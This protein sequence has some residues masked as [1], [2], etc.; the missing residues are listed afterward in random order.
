MPLNK[1]K[2]KMFKSVGWTF[3]P[4]AGCTHGCKYC[5]AR[6]LTERWGRSFKPQL[7]EHF[8]KDKMPGDGSWI[9][10]GSMGDV[11]C[12]G[13]PDEWILRLL[14]FIKECEADNK[15]LL[16]TKNPRRLK[17]F[18]NMLIPIRGKVVVGTTIETNR[19]T[20]WT[21]APTTFARALNIAYLKQY[22]GFKT[23]ISL[24][25]LSDFDLEPLMVMV[26]EIKPEA[27]EVGL[28]NYTS[29]TVKPPDWKIVA[30]IHWLREMNIPYVLKDNLK[31]L[32]AE[33]EK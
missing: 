13:V 28:E 2:G 1:A 26:K 7:R 4:I 17:D 6:R 27:V 14:K 32:G 29:H 25:P 19:E 33:E 11:F 22:H 9:F 21:D 10:V 16:Q 23:F 15:F 31:H 30:L 5:Y 18:V 12:E 3:S 8:F 24:E 20:P